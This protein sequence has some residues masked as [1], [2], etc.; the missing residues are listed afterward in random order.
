MLDGTAAVFRALRR[1]YFSY[2]YDNTLHGF[3]CCI[4]RSVVDRSGIY[5]AF[6]LGLLTVQ[7]FPYLRCVSSWDAKCP[8]ILGSCST[9]DNAWIRVRIGPGNS[10]KVVGFSLNFLGLA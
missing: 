7:Y 6:K 9:A 8:H 1:A 2:L 5:I 4:I 10:V 3:R